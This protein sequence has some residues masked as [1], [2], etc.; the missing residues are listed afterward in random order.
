MTHEIVPVPLLEP[1]EHVH[2]QLFDRFGKLFK[3]VR[4]VERC[5]VSAAVYR[6]SSTE[7][8]RGEI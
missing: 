7:F 5:V 3:L 2:Q 1:I 8:V 6:H 4:H